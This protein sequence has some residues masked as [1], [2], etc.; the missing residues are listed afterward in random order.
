MDVDITRAA[1]L[2]AMTA[3]ERHADFERR[4]VW[5]LNTLPAEYVD[6]LRAD[7]EA[8]LAERDRT[9]RAS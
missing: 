1:D 7:F 5:D 2:D 6:R 4:I 3:A 9:Q 8:F